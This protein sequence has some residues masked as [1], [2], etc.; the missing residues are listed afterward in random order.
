MNYPLAEI[1]DRLSILD[2][3]RSRLPAD[4]ATEAYAT[5]LRTAAFTESALPQQQIRAWYDMLSEVNGR[6]WDLEAYIRAGRDGELGLE[7]IGRRALTIREINGERVGVKAAI[8]EAI[9]E[10]VD[11]KVDH[12]SA[13]ASV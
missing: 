1:I 8:A 6:I 5:L 12:A 3:K 4:A 10:P 9:G 11:V 13:A 7:E 2:L